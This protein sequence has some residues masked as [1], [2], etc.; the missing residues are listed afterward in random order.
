MPRIFRQPARVLLAIAV[1]GSLLWYLWPRP[2]ETVRAA[3]VGLPQ[4]A[5]E[6]ARAV[7]PYAFDF[8]R[9]HGPHPDYQTEWWYYTGNLETPD[10]R[11]FGYQLTFFRRAIRGPSER[12]TRSS[13]WAT[14]QIYMAHFTLTDVSGRQFRFF[15][16]F[17]RGAAGLA[18][19]TADPAYR[20]W[21]GDWSVEQTGPDTYRLRAVEDDI[22]IDLSL[23]DEKGVVLQG[24]EGLSAKGPQPGNAS[25]YYSQTRL[26][27]SGQIS[28]GDQSFT[29]QGDSWLDREFGTS[30]L[31]EGDVGWDWFALQLND[32]S[33]LMLYYLRQK[34]G[35]ISDFSSGTLIKPDG[36]ALD[37]A[38]DD[39]QLTARDT[40]R[41]PYSGAE[42]PSRW[43][44][45]IPDQGIELD[46][47]PYLQDQ[48]LR[49]S[50]VYWEGAVRVSGRSGAQPVSG[51]GYVELTGYHSS[52]GGQF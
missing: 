35:G 11:H 48:E 5:G 20:V 32:G 33:E 17:E 10:Q 49:V 19:A 38:R 47:E 24:D 18:G 13:A 4:N 23:N 9:D 8:P 43:N 39:F 40:W 30:Q 46:V 45:R 52:L 3:I 21:V 2:E 15:E 41:S 51:N 16:R 14:E 7:E 50:Y 28:I 6:F 1:I 44:I 34:D 42:Y 26:R 27:S 36:T 31:S 22:H 29:V 25:N 37:L 12:Q